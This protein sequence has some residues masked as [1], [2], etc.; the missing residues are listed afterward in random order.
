MWLLVLWFYL[1]DISFEMLEVRY[2]NKTDDDEEEPR[3][4][5]VDRDDCPRVNL[6][7]VFPRAKISPD[8]F[9]NPDKKGDKNECCIQMHVSSDVCDSEVNSNFPK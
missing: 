6:V 1:Q 9:G 2:Q 8:V 5:F 4:Y 3:G 7:R